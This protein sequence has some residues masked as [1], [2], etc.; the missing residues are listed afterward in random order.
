VNSSE[1]PNIFPEI[2]PVTRNILFADFNDGP[3]GF[4][5][6]AW[7]CEYEAILRHG[8]AGVAERVI[9]EHSLA[10]PDK[11]RESFQKAHFDSMAMTSTI[12]RQSLGG[13]EALASANVPFVVTKGPGIARAGVTL[14]DR[15]FV[16]L[17][18]LVP[19]SSFGR[20]HDALA[21]VGYQAASTSEQPWRSFNRFCREA[22]NLRTDKGGSIDLHHRISPWYWSTRLSVDYLKRHVRPKEIF[23]VNLP[24]VSPEHN[25]L[26]VALHVV[27]D[28]T[29]PGQTV[30]VWRDLLVLTTKCSAQSVAQVADETGLSGWLSWILKCLPSEV[31]PTDLLELLDSQS[32]KLIGGRRL[33][34]LLPP[35]LGSRHV[36]GEALRLPVP[37]A[38]LFAAGMLVPSSNYLVDRFPDERHRYLVWWRSAIQNVLSGPK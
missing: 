25:L 27:S 12:V 7:E 15:P 17:D 20:A 37:R 31:Q 3:A 14:S 2:G 11:I 8:L 18:V 36:L 28:K 38:A 21:S 33:K 4:N 34:L 29:Q 13:L 5:D 1:F 10:L 9:R 30:R 16:D 26:V 24:L 19:P 23:G 6:T 35:R 22:T 32:R